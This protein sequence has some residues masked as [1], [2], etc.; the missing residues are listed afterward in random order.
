MRMSRHL[1]TFGTGTKYTFFDYIKLKTSIISQSGVTN[2]RGIKTPVYDSNVIIRTHI[3]PIFAGSG[4]QNVY[5]LYFLKLDTRNTTWGTTE[6]E[7][8]GAGAG[9]KLYSGNAYRGTLYLQ[10]AG[11]VS[12][13]DDVTGWMENDQWYEIEAVSSLTAQNSMESGTHRITGSIG[14]GQIEE[15]NDPW[16]L[17]GFN[18]ESDYWDDYSSTYNNK[19][20]GL[21]RTYFYDST[22]TTLLADLRPCRRESDKALGMFDT[23]SGAFFPAMAGSTIAVENVGD[24]E[25]GNLSS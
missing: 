10:V 2:T 11:G 16:F 1:A 5:N 20:G 19:A 6:N 3:M 25:V 13:Y 22:D 9:S 14:T 18:A 12:V 15:N 24:F 4:N 21:Q 17:F 7:V 23:V 8:H